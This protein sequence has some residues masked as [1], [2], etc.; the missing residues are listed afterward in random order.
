M[1]TDHLL[2]SHYVHRHCNMV[3]NWRTDNEELNVHSDHLPITFNIQAGW[4]SPSIMK[5]KIETW[6]LRN[7]NW[8]HYRQVL[9][10]KLEEWKDHCQWFF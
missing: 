7:S 9:S 4:T 3:S 10:R 8:E 2:I 6:N 5:Q 1:E